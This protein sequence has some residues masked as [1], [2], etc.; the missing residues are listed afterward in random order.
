[1]RYALLAAKVLELETRH[2]SSAGSRCRESGKTKEER[3]EKTG[4]RRQAREDRQ[5][6]TGKRRQEGD[7]RLPLRPARVETALATKASPSSPAKGPD[8]PGNFT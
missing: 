5:E 6:K 2:C 1:M 8:Y 7:H 4:K 3:E